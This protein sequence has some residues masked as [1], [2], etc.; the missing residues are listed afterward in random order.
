MT[1]VQ[2]LYLLS[3]KIFMNKNYLILTS[4]I[5]LG[6]IALHIFSKKTR[7]IFDLESL[8]AVG[9]QY[10]D[11]VNRPDPQSEVFEKYDAFLKGLQPADG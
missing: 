9:A 8:W 2:Y 1:C 6:N 7:Q 3:Q 11:Q 5:F 4:Y 10:D